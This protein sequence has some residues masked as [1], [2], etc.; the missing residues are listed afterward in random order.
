MTKNDINSFPIRGMVD[1]TT[2][3]TSATAADTPPAR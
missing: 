1:M 3:I 2:A